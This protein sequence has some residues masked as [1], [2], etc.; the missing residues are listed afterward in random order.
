MTGAG[1][2]RGPQLDGGQ[3]LQHRLSRCGPS[4]WA[5]LGFL[6]VW[7]LGSSVNVGTQLQ[8][9][10][11]EPSSGWEERQGRCISLLRLL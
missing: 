4:M 1:C 10:R 8:G 7:Q 2:Q 9:E 3:E 6:T 11:T 5:C